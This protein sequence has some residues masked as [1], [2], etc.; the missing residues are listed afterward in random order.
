LIIA[1]GDEFCVDDIKAFSGRL[2]SVKDV[3]ELVVGEREAHGAPVLDLVIPAKVSGVQSSKVDRW[4][5]D[6][7]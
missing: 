6:K 4:F 7:F 3:V 1:G 2:G 5:L